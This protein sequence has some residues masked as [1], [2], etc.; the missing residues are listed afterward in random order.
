MAKTM[1]KLISALA[2]WNAWDGP[3]PRTGIPRDITPTLL[4]LIERPEALVL[5]GIRRGGK[6]TIMLQLVEALVVKGTDRTSILYVNFD[7]PAIE[8]R[9]GTVLL[10]EIYQAFRERLCP[11]GRAI[12]FLDE[13]QHVPEWERW[14]NGRLV[15]ENISI[16]VS[17]SSAQLMSRE[18][19]TLLTGRN[20][21]VR[22]FP[23]SFSEYIRFKG[24]DIS[25]GNRLLLEKQRHVLR[26]E[27]HNFLQW[28]C[29][30]EVT[31]EQSDEV[32]ARLL[33]QYLDDILFKDVVMRHQIR[34]VRLLRDM[35]VYLLT[36]TACRT[37]LQSLR[38]T[39]GI[40][41]DMARAYLTYLQEP[42]LIGEVR[43]YA[44][45]LKAQQVAPR[46]IYAGDLG[47]R[48]VAALTF[49]EDIGR[50]EET[51]VFHALEMRKQDLFYFAQQSGEV[52]FL[53]CRGL[54]AQEMIQVTHSGLSEEKIRTRELGPLTAT[55]LFPGSV[56]TLI[57]DDW[58]DAE[59]PRPIKNRRLWEWLL[60]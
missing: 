49:D 46:K 42:Y 8:P 5:T 1:N 37:T 36:H 21:T 31:L 57:T 7:E 43:S 56:R 52:D 9:R 60:D 2:P 51:A 58:P 16:V 27:L 17:G 3:S 44:R 59:I 20:I 26:H 6:S 48:H 28:G 13:V 18:I 38:K 50:L 41:L 15:T 24:V 29:F 47:L 23:L 53:V 30:P 12:V 54:K 39:F 34:D 45:S 10:E 40:S 19:A 11:K 32:R 4:P 14:V 22:I 35:A 33:S 25:T 55:D